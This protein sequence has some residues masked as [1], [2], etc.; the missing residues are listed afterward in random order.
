MEKL[1]ILRQK[2]REA[3][4]SLIDDIEAMFDHIGTCGTG[5][6]AKHSTRPSSNSRSLRFQFDEAASLP[7]STSTLVPANKSVSGSSGS[8][9]NF[10]DKDFVE[11]RAVRKC[12]SSTDTG[13][14]LL[15]V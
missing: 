13:K 1:D 2:F 14:F 8:K 5:E 4:D 3:T 6:T 15:L 12:S 7:S 10:V 9:V 11:P